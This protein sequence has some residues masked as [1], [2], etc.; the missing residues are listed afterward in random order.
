MRYRTS[1]EREV[2]VRECW[3]PMH[4]G[5]RLHARI[6]CPPDAEAS[7]VPALLEYL[8][9]RKGDWTAPRDAQRHPWYA[10]HGYASVRVDLRGSGNSEGVMLDE[11]TQ[12]ELDDA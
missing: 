11:Y 5:V 8:P 10:G 9:Y 6:W 2:A 7:P 1:F 3:I 12:V 4:D